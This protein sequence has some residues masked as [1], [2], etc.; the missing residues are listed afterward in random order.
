MNQSMVFGYGNVPEF[1]RKPDYIELR[2]YVN[3]WKECQ[4]FCP[5]F[6][7]AHNAQNEFKLLFNGIFL[8]GK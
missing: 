3:F 8:I 6:D 5:S 4:E 7:K 1:C 2:R